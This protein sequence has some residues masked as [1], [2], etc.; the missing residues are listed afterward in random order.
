MIP[1]YAFEAVGARIFSLDDPAVVKDSAALDGT[2]G[3]AFV[4][5]YVTSEIRV[6]NGSGWNKLRR[7]MQR[8]AHD[9][10]LT[11]R[12]TGIRDG[13]EGSMVTR[14]LAIGAAGFLNVPMNEGGSGFQFKVELTAYSAKVAF[15]G[16]DVYVVAKRAFR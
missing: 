16:A 8:L 12:V 11:A 5:F 2:G 14:T 13:G 9:G 3:T 15:S 10:T 1:F 7:I 6:A 4:P